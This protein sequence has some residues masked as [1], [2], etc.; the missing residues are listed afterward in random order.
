M[1]TNQDLL[2][3][4]DSFE[5][6]ERAEALD[7]LI[8]R[9]G[10]ELPEV[11]AN[12]NMHFHSFFS[13]N[14]EGWSP[15]H[16]AWEARR[17]G[18]Y[19]AGLCDFDVLDGLEEFLC[20]GRKLGLRSTVNLETRAFLKECADSDISS[21]G[22]PGVTYIMGAGFTGI[23][24]GG[25]DAAE[26][27]D[28]F[29]SGARERNLGLI[30]RI[31]LHT[32]EIAL[33]YE[34]DVLPLTPRGVATERHIT[35]AYVNKARDVFERPH[36]TAEFW[37]RILGKEFEVVVEL[38]ADR[39]ALE[40]VVR[41]RLAK[42]GGLGYEQPSPDTFPPV[43]E[44]IRWVISCEAVPMVT[45]LDGTSAGESD[46]RAMLECM[47]G[48]GAAALNVIPD[49]NWNVAD[50]EQQKT[51]LANLNAIVDAAVDMHMPINIGTE[52]NKRGLPFNDDLECEALRPHRETFLKGARIMVGH[53][54]LLRYAGMSYIGEK[55]CAVYSDPAERN[56]VFEAVGARPPLTEEQAQ[57]LDDMGPDKALMA[58]IAV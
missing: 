5:E 13:Y 4:L 25:T 35:A 16:I 29:R 42:Q 46:A 18:L 32:P 20:A 3:Q 51:K 2:E 8:E 14:A 57:Q 48:K 12:V 43:D 15:T 40:E 36:A 31:N 33:D 23:P 55:A 10:D 41:S 21:P 1:N 44:F 28:A 47:R 45:W 37:S 50:P 26:G 39:P 9:H 34:R 38:L 6:S 49:R 56:R 52:M 30:G 19:A 53:S 11:G 58:L 24:V 22:E 17:A 7:L 54:L 27:L